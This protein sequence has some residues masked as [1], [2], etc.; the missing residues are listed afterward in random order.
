[1]I[2]TVENLKTFLESNSNRLSDNSPKYTISFGLPKNGRALIHLMEFGEENIEDIN[3]FTWEQTEFLRYCWKFGGNTRNKPLS[4][5][6]V[7]R[8]F[9]GSL[10]DIN[11]IRT[12]EERR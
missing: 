1:M 11:F 2:E 10:H 3:C 7:C 4:W 12:L 9:N 8:A 5:M 6:S